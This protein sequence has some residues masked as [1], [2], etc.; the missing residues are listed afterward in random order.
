MF[1]ETFLLNGR[2]A[3]PHSVLEAIKLGMWDFEPEKK[4][5]AEYSA[6]RALPGTHEKLE[7]MARRIQQG[8]PLWHPEDRRTYDESHPLD[9]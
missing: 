7:I 1:P 2:F 5:A 8:Q 4:R 3:V 6:T 9:D